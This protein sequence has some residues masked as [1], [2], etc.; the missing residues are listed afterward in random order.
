MPDFKDTSK[1]LFLPFKIRIIVIIHLCFVFT[2]ISAYATYPFMGKYFFSKSKINILKDILGKIPEKDPSSY[3]LDVSLK[4]RRERNSFRFLLLDTKLQNH[5]KSYYQ[6]VKEDL[7]LSLGQ[8]A[9]IAIKLVILGIPPYIQAWC[10]FSIILCILLLKRQ[11]EA[12]YGCWILLLIVLLFAI[13][14]DSQGKI[15]NDTH[16]E[17]YPKEEFIAQYYLD[18]P[19]GKKISEQYQQLK[20]GWERYL[21]CEFAGQ[22]PSQDPALYALQLEE[23]EFHFHV[24]ELNR[25]YLSGSLKN[26]VLFLPFQQKQSPLQLTLY[27][28]WHLFFSFVFIYFFRNS[29]ENPPIKGKTVSFNTLE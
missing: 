23:G 20:K 16:D 25:D 19:L 18:Q 15:A 12:V 1:N 11:K 26:Q 22:K 17:L 28:V 3:G 24:A 6:E 2:V 14:M 21:I 10:F 8:K 13:R 5:L 27:F 29:V 9:K 7:S 4:E